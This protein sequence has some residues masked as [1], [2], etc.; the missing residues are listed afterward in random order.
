MKNTPLN[1][2][3]WNFMNADLYVKITRT[4]RLQANLLQHSHKFYFYLFIFLR[5][6]WVVINIITDQIFKNTEERK[7]SFYCF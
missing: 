2:R 3:V 1:E 7:F 6:Q 4:V 5:K